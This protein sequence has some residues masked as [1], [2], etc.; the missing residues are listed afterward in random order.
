[1][2]GQLRLLMIVRYGQPASAWSTQ[3][4]NGFVG[5]SLCLHEHFP[6]GHFGVVH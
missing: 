6:K 3:T 1:M 2:P 5:A 4:A